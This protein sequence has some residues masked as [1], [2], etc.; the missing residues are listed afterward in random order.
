MVTPKFDPRAAVAAYSSA[1]KRFRELPGFDQQ[2]VLRAEAGSILKT[3]A[4][5]T[6]V[7]TDKR[8]ILRARARAI[9]NAIGRNKAG[10]NGLEISI[11]SGRRGGFPGEVWFRTRNNR[12]QQAGV[13]S[14]GGTYKPAWIHFKKD[15]WELSI[16]YG[17]TRAA[18]EMKKL[19]PNATK[20]VGLA[21][22]SIIQI[23]DDLGIDLNAVPG[24][25]VSASGIAKAR[26]A[27]ASSG[28]GYKNGVGTQGGDAVRSYVQLIC[29]L[30]YLQK[31]GM[32]RTLAG[33]VAGRAKYI[34]ASY[35]KGAFDS[36]KRVEAA[37]PNIAR[38]SGEPLVNAL[39]S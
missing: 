4:G 2:T 15:D 39:A 13:V 36:L 35:A 19:I 27:V 23:A 9:S 24:G 11:N 10:K 1:F 21:R 22:Q 5:R 37:F 6:K 3:W 26:A 29:R 7:G 18:E 14:D 8:A 20:S 34:E 33:V 17:A 32:D 12:F 25:G 38:V 30:P 28:R 16:N 31:I